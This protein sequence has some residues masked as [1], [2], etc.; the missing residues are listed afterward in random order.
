MRRGLRVKECRQPLVAGKGK[1]ADPPIELP[2][3]TQPYQ[4]FN[5]RTSEI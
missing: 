2:E 1:E 4:H 3:G 5:F